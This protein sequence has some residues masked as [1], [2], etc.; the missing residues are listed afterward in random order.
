MRHTK[1]IDLL[2]G[3]SLLQEITAKGWVKTFRNNQFIAL[4]DGSTIHNIQCVVD[5]ENFP[6]ELL[7]KVTTG[8]AIA[9][10][11]TLIE[12]QGAGQK[13][14]IQ[15]KSL[16]IL[17]ESDPEK[18]P[19]QPKKHSLEFLR[20]NAHL[21]VRTNVFGAIM[22][23][24]SV[25]SY[26]VHKY[27][28][29]SGFVYVNT[30]IITGSDA[31]GA[32][33]MFQV[34]SLSLDGNAPKNED[35][36]INYKED[37][38]GKHTNL[39]VS[40]QLEAET[41]AMALG[42]VYT[43]GPTFRAE[44]SNTSRHLAE[45]WMIEPEVAFNDLDANMDLAE[46]FIKSII[47][48]VMEKCEDDLKFLEQRLKDEE[49]SKP[50][51][52]RSEMSLIEKLQF[53][54]ENNF[55]RVSY[56]ETQPEEKKEDILSEDEE[57]VV[58]SVETLEEKLEIG[59]PIEFTSAEKHSFSEWLQLTKAEP[60]K[61]KEEE[62]EAIEPQKEEKLQEEKRKKE[63]LINRFIETNPKIIPNKNM[64][65]VPVFIEKNEDDQSFLMT[66]TL[67]KIYLEQKKYQKAIQAYEIL[68]LKYP[69]KSSLFADRISNIK[70]LQNYNS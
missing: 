69:E 12:S 43:F 24:R 18:F 50:Q 66:E 25:L 68:I 16:E 14:E 11:G 8:A 2:N 48:H 19:I 65:S 55:K 22:R 34:T 23:V 44:N 30:P 37:F 10:K 35:G 56:T 61:R 64:S 4:N 7:K 47:R 26:A 58:T 29:E 63:E 15:V 45:F 67:A 32:G 9:V 3:S 20:E 53:V 60:I 36:T 42:Q 28:Q 54:L 52:E 5:F 51:A 17:G 39:T 1:V 49:K 62:T 70:M 6:A 21:R 59:T 27:F 46:D 38:F 40:G 33:E 41:Y 31:E 13:F 57:T